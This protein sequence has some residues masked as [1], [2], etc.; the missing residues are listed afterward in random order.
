MPPNKWYDFSFARKTRPIVRPLQIGTAVFK[1]HSLNVK[2]VKD[3]PVED[4][5]KARAK[6]LG[7]QIFTAQ[8]YASVADKFVEK[9]TNTIVAGVVTIALVKTACVITLYI[10]KKIL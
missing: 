1:K 7:E 4:D 5:I 3:Q 9:T 2:F 10:A 6:E 8:A